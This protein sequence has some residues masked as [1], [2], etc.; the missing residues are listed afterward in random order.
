MH[1]SVMKFCVFVAL[2][3]ASLCFQTLAQVQSTASVAEA[4]PATVVGPVAY[5]DEPLVIERSETVV[6]VAADGTGWRERTLAARLQSDTGVK[7]YSVL[8]I[9]YA[10][11]SQ[12]VEIAYARVIH[13]YGHAG[14]G[15]AH[16]A[17]LQ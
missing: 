17:V 4:Y 7:R 8:N 12:H 14:G 13:A 10:G 2:V 15:D 1:P 3:T 11:N 16:G 9:A 6:E 5:A